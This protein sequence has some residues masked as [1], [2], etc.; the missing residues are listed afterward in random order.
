MIIDLLP[1]QARVALRDHS[2]EK[3]PGRGHLIAH[4]SESLVA[5]RCCCAV[6]PGEDAH[7]SRRTQ[8]ELV[9]LY[10]ELRSYRAVDALLGCITRR[11]GG[12]CRWLV[13]RAS[14]RR[15]CTQPGELSGHQWGFLLALDTRFKRRRSSRSDLEVLARPSVL[16]LERRFE[17]CAARADRTVR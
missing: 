6:D 9:A 1:A 3:L 11:L 8:V 15:R 12:M 5:V 2:H 14:S 4:P 16:H 17:C 7:E 10:E 13:S